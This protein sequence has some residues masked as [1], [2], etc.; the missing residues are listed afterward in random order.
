VLP[1]GSRPPSVEPVSEA[2]VR[3]LLAADPRLAA[4]RPARTARV[5]SGFY[6][7]QAMELVGV[8]AADA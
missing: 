3:A 8:R 5:S 2:R 7:S 4:W 1:V 6:G